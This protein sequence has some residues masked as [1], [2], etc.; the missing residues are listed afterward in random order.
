MNCDF[1]FKKIKSGTGKMYVTSTGK[2]YFFCSS[3]CEKYYFM[4][5]SIK[6]HKWL[7]HETR[8]TN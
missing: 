7:K 8:N 2:I 3:K 5:R 6:K 4:N 1:C